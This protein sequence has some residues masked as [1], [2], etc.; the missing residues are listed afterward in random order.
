S[1]HKTA[2]YEISGRYLGFIVDLVI[3]FTL[4]GVGVVMIAGAGSTLNQQF[5]LPVFLVSLIMVIIVGAAMM[6]KLDKVVTVIAS[7]TPFLLLCIVIISIYTFLTM[8]AS[9]SGSEQAA[10]TS[11]G[12]SQKWF[13]ASIK[14]VSF[15]TAVGSGMALIIGEA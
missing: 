9:I 4:F 6:L 13:T 15:N 8:E 12:D 11:S 5:D 14:Y 7:I 2:I 10:K 1:S 3:I